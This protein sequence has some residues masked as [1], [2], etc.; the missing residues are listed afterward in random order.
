MRATY[1]VMGSVASALLLVQL[2]SEWQSAQTVFCILL[3]GL[4]FFSRS[5]SNGQFLIIAF[6]TAFLVEKIV[7]YPVELFIFPLNINFI[8]NSVAFIVQFSV[9]VLLI[10]L[11]KNRMKLSLVL[12]KGKSPCILEKN[13]A[14]GPLYGLLICYASIDM[15]AFIE[16]IIRNLDRLGVDESFAKQF[17]DLTFFYDNFEYMK[18]VLMA[19]TIV[20]LYMGVVVRKR[21]NQTPKLS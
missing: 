21:H 10:Y 3:V 14:E 6:L 13:Y 2:I 18:G 8:G 5:D 9:D 7:F 17:W 16:N 11:V 19:L 15:L 4:A 1:L 12:T 20:V